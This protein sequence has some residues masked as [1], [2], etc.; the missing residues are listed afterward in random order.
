MHAGWY[1]DYFSM[2]RRS[3][4]NIKIG[5]IHVTAPE[6]TILD[7]AMQRAEVTGR[8]VPKTIILDSIQQVPKSIKVLRDRVDYYLEV[9]NTQQ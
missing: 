5:I 1:Q 3:Y 2:L 7:R 8:I 6:E 9:S 4:P